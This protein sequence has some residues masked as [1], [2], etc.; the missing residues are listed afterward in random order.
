MKAAEIYLA[1]RDIDKAIE[2]W[3]RVTVLNPEHPLAH[4]RLAMVHERLGHLQQAVT[5]YLAIASLLQRSGNADKAQ[6]IV[7]KALQLMP[8]S[9]EAR[10]AQSLLKT[11]QLLPRPLRGKG[12]TGPIAM[13]KVRQLKEPAEQAASNLDPV[14]EARQKA[15]TKLA[16]RSLRLQRR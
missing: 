14:E 8:Q 12:G 10:Q 16:E 6:E 3:G 4:S 5:E 1:Q 15:L 2:N 9:E 11:G 13:A 7:T